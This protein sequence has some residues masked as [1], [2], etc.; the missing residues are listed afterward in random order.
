MRIG[1]TVTPSETVRKGGGVKK[2]G[3]YSTTSRSTAL[4]STDIMEI[5]RK[6]VF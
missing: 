2:A 3:Y 5:R 4:D 1:E 6:S